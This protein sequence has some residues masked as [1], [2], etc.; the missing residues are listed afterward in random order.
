MATSPDSASLD[1]TSSSRAIFAAGFVIFGVAS[2]ISGPLLPFIRVDYRFSLSQTGSLFSAQF[3]GFVLSVLVGGVVADVWGKRLFVLVGTAVLT[4]GLALVGCFHSRRL[5][6]IGFFMMGV[7]FGGFDAGLSPLVGDLNPERRGLA[8]NLLH[9][10]LGVGALLGPFWAR[11]FA[12]ALGA[13]RHVYSIT[14]A[15]SSAFLLVFASYPIPKYSQARNAGF[16]YLGTLL[17]DKRLVLLAL[18]MC[19]YVGLES[20]VNGWTFSFMTEAIGSTSPLATYTLSLFWG[21]LTLGRLVA[22]YI[23]ERLG[24][25]LVILSC[26]AGSLLAGAPGVMGLG[27][28]ATMI[29]CAALGFFFS[30]IFPTVLAQGTSYFPRSTGTVAGI[31]IAAGAAGGALVPWLIGVVADTYDLSRGMAVIPLGCALMLVLSF[32]NNRLSRS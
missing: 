6:A 3:A 8:L 24:Y 28:Y 21:S 26:C 22:A 23:S 25:K 14:A 1:V 32:I 19:A 4:C 10:F 15:C 20:G 29:S 18:L 31:L 27:V 5:L 13:W 2:T 17:C 16:G 12:A 7:G 9:M 11:H 30:G